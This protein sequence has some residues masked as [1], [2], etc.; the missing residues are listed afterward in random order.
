MSTHLQRHHGGKTPGRRQ[1]PASEKESAP[2]QSIKTMFGANRKLKHDSNRAKMITKSIAEFFVQDLR[3][4]SVVENIGF[5]RMINTLE[6]QYTIPS[7]Q[8]FTDKIIPEMYDKVK[9]ELLGDLEKAEA[10]SVTS[11]GWTSRATESYVTVT[12]HYID[13][14]WN[15]K[16]KVLQTRKT[17]ESHTGENIGHILVNSFAEWN[18]SDKIFALVTDNARN[19]KSAAREANLSNH[20]GC[21]AHT[22]NLAAQRAVGVGALQKSLVKIRK[23]VAYFHRSSTALEVL[24]EKCTL[25]KLPNLKLKMD[26]VTRWN[27]TY[28]MVDRYLQL[29]AAVQASL[30]SKDLRIKQDILKPLALTDEEI[31]VAETLV[32]VMKP[33]KTATVIMC[34]EHSPTLSVVWP[35]YQQILRS[36]RIQDDDSRCTIAMK[37]AIA[38]DLA[39]RYDHVETFL[40]M[41][42]FLDPRFKTLPSLNDVDRVG[43][44]SK[45]T[46][47]VAELGNQPVVKTEPV[48]TAEV[49]PLLA[50]LPVEKPQLS[51]SDS[52]ES[53]IKKKLKTENGTGCALS[54]LLGDVYIVKEEKRSKSNLEM[55]SDEVAAYQKVDTLL[56]NQNP[57]L[58]WKENAYLYPRLSKLAKRYHCVPGTS[59]PSER[60]FSCA[61]DIVTAQRSTLK[62]KNVDALIFLKKNFE[63]C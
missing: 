30:L 4:F 25:L 48:D 40:Q 58:W 23:T 10:V 52:D 51:G 50:A 49:L 57:L 32:L 21:F 14:E 42:S 41:A 31:I 59:V 3:P 5:R 22:L 37:N 43:L 2:V 12:C 34:D 35:L 27:S 33:M 1:P 47:E 28:E 20:I 62:S 13:D 53:P 56:M 26:V 18:I 55:A 60:I 8:H 7:R 11:D 15:L 54:D 19:M 36:V 24:K 45:L 6:P 17:N 29:Q 16:N 61:G 44:V 46:L 9:S 38:D 63:P 39:G